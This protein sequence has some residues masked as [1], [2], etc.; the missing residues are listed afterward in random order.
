MFFHDAFVNLRN[1]FSSAPILHRPDLTL[2]FMQSPE[3]KSFFRNPNLEA[4][5]RNMGNAKDFI[6]IKHAAA[7]SS[8]ESI[9]FF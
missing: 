9:C 5:R 2:S 7:F 1:Q 6:P 4:H 8:L 3:N